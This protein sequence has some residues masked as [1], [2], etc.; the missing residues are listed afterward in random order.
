MDYIRR[1]CFSLSFFT[2]ACFIKLAL[3]NKTGHDQGK[4]YEA[5]GVYSGRTFEILAIKTLKV[6]FPF[7]APAFGPNL[8]KYLTNA[9]FRG[10]KG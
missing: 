3:P 7:D 5:L 10:F 1:G 4:G 9:Q 6:I 2:A 8:S